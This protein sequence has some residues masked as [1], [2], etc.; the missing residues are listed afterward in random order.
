MENTKSTTGVTGLLKDARKIVLRLIH[1]P[2][3]HSFQVEAIVACG[4]DRSWSPRLEGSKA[5][6]N[7]H[8]EVDPWRS[9]VGRKEGG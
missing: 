9:T 7:A 5:P 2:R 1:D 6:P 3:E 4:R 8:A